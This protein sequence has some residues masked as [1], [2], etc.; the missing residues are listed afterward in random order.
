MFENRIDRKTTPKTPGR[1]TNSQLEI[2]G[3]K[4]ENKNLGSEFTID[5]KNSRNSKI[6]MAVVTPSIRVFWGC[7]NQY[8]TIFIYTPIYIYYAVLD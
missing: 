3:K 7:L 2:P 4:S 6:K 8:G 5:A 1:H